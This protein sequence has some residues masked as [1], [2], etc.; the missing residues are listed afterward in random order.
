MSRTPRASKSW[1]RRYAAFTFLLIFGPGPAAFPQ[2][3]P[4]VTATPSPTPSEVENLSRTVGTEVNRV[5]STCKRAVVRVAATDQHGLHIGTGFF[6]DPHG[7]IFTDFSV[8]GN[9]WDFSVEFDDKKY[10]AKCLVADARSGVAILKIEADTPF[11]PISRADG[12]EPSDTVAL[13]GYFRDLPVSY[14]IGPVQGFDQRAL[15]GWLLPAH[16]RAGMVVL[17]GQQ[18]APL[19]N[20]R[21]EV[22]GIVVGQIGDAACCA[23]PVRAAEKIRRDYVRFGEPRPGYLGVTIT[24]SPELVNDEGIETSVA[25]LSPGSAALRSGLRTGDVLVKVNNEPVNRP[26]DVLDISFYLTGGDEV[27]VTVKRGGEMLTVHVEA[28]DEPGSRRDRAAKRGERLGMRQNGDP[29][30]AALRLERDR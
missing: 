15:G 30:P 25:E 8:G 13:I 22:V 27:P 26:S 4:A 1:R 16:I 19:V 2:S 6:V 14:T 20:L 7:T 21:G 28:G 10:P 12:L 29:Q 17:P 11:L 5:F 9:S 23:L 24:P 18:G 3:E